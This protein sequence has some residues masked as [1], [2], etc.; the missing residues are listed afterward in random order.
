VKAQ[1][2]KAAP[3]S[4]RLGARIGDP[5]G[6]PFD[7]PS[8]PLSSTAPE[9]GGAGL[10]GAL[11]GVAVEAFSSQLF[12][13][14]A[15]DSRPPELTLDPDLDP[16]AALLL[17]VGAAGATSGLRPT[18]PSSA[19]RAEMGKTQLQEAPSPGEGK[20]QLNHYRRGN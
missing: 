20:T 16:S 17:R 4:P 19:S 3:A 11:E 13:G 18:A 9:R 2:A 8:L 6:A 1:Q 7:F 15:H 10:A 12:K 5:A 14:T